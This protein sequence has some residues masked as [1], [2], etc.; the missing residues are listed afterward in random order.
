MYF[1]SHS[2]LILSMNHTM[3]EWTVDLWKRQTLRL[4]MIHLFRVAD[5]AGLN[6]REAARIFRLASVAVVICLLVFV[7]QKVYMRAARDN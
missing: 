3:V 2:P 5:K 4:M 1:S 6:I 7:P